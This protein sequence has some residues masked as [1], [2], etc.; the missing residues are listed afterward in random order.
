MNWIVGMRSG[1][2]LSSLL[3]HV[4][5]SD[6]VAIVDEREALIRS[7]E[8]PVD[9]VIVHTELFADRYPWEWVGTI[10][11]Q[12]P[13]AHIVII[14]SD[15]V[16]DSLWQEVLERLAAEA[17][18]TVAPLGADP[19]EIAQLAFGT[20]P[21]TH[22]PSAGIV[23]AIWS[24]AC[25]DGA[26]TI[27]LSTALAL[28]QHTS[29]RIG[30]LDLNLKNPELRLY[31]PRANHMQSNIPLRPKLQTGQL[32]AAELWEQCSNYPRIPNL[33]LLFGSHRRDTA[34]D[35]TPEMI[36]TLLDTARLTFDITLLDVSS[37]PDNAATVCAVRSADYR[38]LV[39]QQHMGSYVWSWSEWYACYWQ[40]CGLARED[41][42]VLFNRYTVQGE[43][44]ERM[45]ATMGMPLAGVVPNVASPRGFRSVQEESVLYD[46]AGVAYVSAIHGL[47]SALATAAGA[48][49]LPVME[50]PR[51]K[52]IIQLLSGLF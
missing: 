29:L 30:L 14:A 13:S 35:V 2:S 43:Q 34:V 46:R 10:R 11:H 45:A 18:I 31:V 40:W 42:H 3:G 22:T 8:K 25:K 36:G 38:W 1:D 20:L 21:I 17:R 24:A 41:I 26:T 16:Y 49:P 12:Q 15:D 7:L 27:A 19:F 6:T 4:P 23:T 37:V 51:R 28:A 33:R 50:K 39:A 32:R 9:G 52:P 48:M 44:P 5:A 47:A